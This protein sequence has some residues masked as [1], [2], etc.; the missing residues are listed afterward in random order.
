[1]V[2]LFLLQFDE[3]ILEACLFVLD[4]CEVPPSGRGDPVNVVRV[5]SAMVSAATSSNTAE[6]KSLYL[7]CSQKPAVNVSDCPF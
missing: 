3:G 6:T 1:M 2:S 5:I 4:N 7:P